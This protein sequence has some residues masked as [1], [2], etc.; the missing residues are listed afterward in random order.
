[1]ASFTLHGIPVS[2]GVAIGRAHL[3]ASAALDVQ[4]YL[5][6]QEQIEAEVQ[7]LENAITTVHKELETIWTD[8]PKDAPVELRAILDVHAM[9]LSDPMISEA[10]LDRKSV[11]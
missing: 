6:A 2:R 3:I 4:H 10:P 7:R 9:I 1:M 11:V 5:I 8:I